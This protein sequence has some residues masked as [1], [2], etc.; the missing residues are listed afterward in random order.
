MPCLF[1]LIER[2]GKGLREGRLGQPRRDADAQRPR[3]QLEQGK[4]PLGIQPIEQRGQSG[5]DSG[6]RHRGKCRDGLAQPRRGGRPVG[7]GPE[8]ADRLGRI[9]D[10]VA[11]QGEQHR[12]DP[13]PDQRPHRRGFHRWKIQP[14]GQGG[15]RPASVGIGCKAQIGRDQ[16]QLAVAGPR[17]DQAVD[18]GA[19][20]LHAQSS[21][22]S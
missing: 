21:S 19:K 9:A 8:Q 5:M 1:H 3:R 12:I 22:S 20:I 7:L 18:E 13:L 10:I 17:V 11:R 14:A 2:Q 16:L 6:A 15:Q 4:T